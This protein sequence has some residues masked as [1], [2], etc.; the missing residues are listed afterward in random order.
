MYCGSK[1][2]LIV[3]L[4]TILLLISGSGIFAQVPG[5]TDLPPDLVAR[6]RQAPMVAIFN[7]VLWGSV[8]GGV[9]FAGLH[10][11]DDSK[12]TEERY[13]ISSIL[14]ESVVGAT[15]GGIIGLGVG[16]YMSLLGVTFE[17]NL[18]LKNLFPTNEFDYHEQQRR[19]YGNR[20][21]EMAK[22][23]IFSLQFRF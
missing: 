3:V 7:N 9:A 4:T 16:I 12:T 23:Q 14:D 11:I 1:S 2:F 17:N 5:T 6:T 8:A 13:K 18:V 22:E 15:W 21:N 10:M 19:L 20:K